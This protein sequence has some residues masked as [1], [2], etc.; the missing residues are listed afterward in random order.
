MKR[1]VNLFLMGL[2]VL[3]VVS[4]VGMAI[5]FQSEYKGLSN[6]YNSAL[7]KLE[8]KNAELDKRMLEINK[9]REELDSRERSLVDIVKE[10]NLT[11]EKQASLGGFYENIKGEK[12]TLEEN[13][14]ATQQEVRK[15]RTNYDNAN[16]DLGI[17]QNTIKNKDETINK[18]ESK[19]AYHVVKAKEVSSSLNQTDVNLAAVRNNLEDLSSQLDELYMLTSDMEVPAQIS[20]DAKTDIKEGIDDMRSYINGKFDNTLTSM[21]NSVNNARKSVSSITP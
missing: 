5:Y 10:L 14:S 11:R 17:C 9:T 13:L 1:D 20:A 21:R 8:E 15:W 19:I 7:E 2:L 18:K 12:Q 16:R 6:E 3:I 4:M